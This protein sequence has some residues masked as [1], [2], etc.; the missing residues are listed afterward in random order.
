[1]VLSGAS[2]VLPGASMVLP[3]ASM[4]LP[5]ASMVLPGANMVLS[6]TNK[7]LPGANM[8][9]SG[10]NKVLPGASMVLSGTVHAKHHLRQRRISPYLA[11][12]TVLG[13]NSDC[14]YSAWRKSCPAKVDLPAS[15][16]TGRVNR[17]KAFQ[18]T[19]IIFASV[20]ERKPT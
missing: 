17:P 13:T 8:V 4:V 5:G 19:D 11:I 6:G 9:L 7:V 15:G 3:G 18:G 20:G 2:M 1:M 14:F 16:V 10:A 12:A